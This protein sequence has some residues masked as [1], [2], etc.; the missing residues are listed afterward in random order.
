[1]VRLLKGAATKQLTNDGLHPLAEFERDGS[2]PSPWA[3]G[4]WKVYLDNEEAIENA[5]IYVWD[6]PGKEDKPRQT[7]SFVKP[8]YGLD[9]GLVTYD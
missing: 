4:K 9:P 5:I 6:N 1:M 7:W 8:F 2:I 3:V